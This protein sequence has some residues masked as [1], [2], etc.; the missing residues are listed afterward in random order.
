MKDLFVLVADQDM[1]E[2]LTAL[3]Q[4]HES[5]GIR[6]VAYEVERHLQRDAGCR[7]TWRYCQCPAFARL[8]HCLQQWFGNAP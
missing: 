4:R 7:T 5:L 6:P 2:T 3:L 8:K 1:R